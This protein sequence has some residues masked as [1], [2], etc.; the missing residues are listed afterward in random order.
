MKRILVV[1][2]MTALTVSLLV[3]LAFASSVK[4]FSGRIDKGGKIVF[5]ALRENGKYTRAGLFNLD[6][7]PVNCDV[8]SN[9]AFISTQNVVDVSNKRK[10]SYKF[11]FGGDNADASARVSGRF[12]RKGNKAEGVVNIS[13]FAPGG[14]DSTNCT[15]DGPRDW[16]ARK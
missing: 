8:G 9:K 7:I 1:V 15:T 11:T 6:R 14:T 13:K 5:S 16:T 2:F 3:G 12:N 10:F 4:H